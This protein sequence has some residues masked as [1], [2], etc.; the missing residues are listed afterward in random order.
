LTSSTV[1]NARIKPWNWLLVRI[2]GAVLSP[3]QAP[4]KRELAR[5]VTQPPT[6]VEV[7]TRHGL[8]PCW[9]F[10]PHPEAPLASDGQTP[11]VYLHMHG[12][13]FILDNPHQEE[14]LC[15]L[16]ASDVG[17]AVINIDYSCAPQVTYP[18]AHEQCADVAEWAARSGAEHGWDGS[19][20]AV[21]GGS[22]G[23]NLALAVAKLVHAGD[24]PDVR[25]VAA[26]VPL[27]DATLPASSYT[28]TKPHP[29]IGP[30]IVQQI[31]NT[32]FVDE[33]R[34]SEPLASPGLD[35]DVAE[36]LP[37]LVLLSGGDDSL[38]PQQQEF[39]SRLRELGLPVTHRVF[40]GQDHD[41]IV[42]D[43]TPE[44]V[45]RESAELITTHLLRHLA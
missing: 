29:V 8:V 10:A 2:V 41:Y 44:A 40:E 45:A 4:P 32:Y 19:R 18:V 26:L 22:A 12:G 3:R 15:R 42:V 33:A 6:R 20:M 43:A 13:G 25:A 17:A 31:H 27:V 35:P 23:G 36:W 38:A 5:F 11:P 21:G 9:I 24:E 16:I 7:P 37:P 28:S 14:F 30:W 1:S 34:R 39:V